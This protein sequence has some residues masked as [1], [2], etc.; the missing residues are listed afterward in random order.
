MRNPN[1]T[2]RSRG[3]ME[4]CTYCVQRINAAKI[5][6]E[7]ENNRTIADG[8]II[9]ACQQA[10]PAEAIVF[11]NI[12]DPNSRVSKL[13]A[14]TRNYGLLDGFE[15]APAHHVS[16]ARA[17]S[18]SGDSRDRWRRLKQPVYG[19]MAEFET[20][21]QILQAALRTHAAGYRRID[22]YSPMP[23]EGLAEAV[24]FEW[25]SLP[26][27][28]FIGGLLGGCTGFF[29]CWYANVISFPLNIGGKPLQ[30]LAGLDSHHL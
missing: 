21:E 26:M 11:G 5:R 23:V 1:V 29:M 16:G 2:V 22:A 20:P 17:K 19:L 12:N 28:V 7:V 27:V 10:C 6:S 8:E 9:T 15:H 18:Q 25:T 30:Q 4:K 3:V 14:Q 13:K 24:G